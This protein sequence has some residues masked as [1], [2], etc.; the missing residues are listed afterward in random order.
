[1]MK[2]KKEG[3][4][5]KVVRRKWVNEARDH[6]RQLGEENEG[7][8]IEMTSARNYTLTQTE[9]VVEYGPDTYDVKRT[10]L[11]CHDITQH[12]SQITRTNLLPTLSF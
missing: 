8:E 1:M 2:Q 7:S 11:Q 6:G 4:S 3:L 5:K 10:Y 12:V 9:A